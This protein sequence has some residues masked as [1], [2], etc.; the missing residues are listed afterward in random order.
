MRVVAWPDWLA[1]DAAEIARG[2]ER[3]KVRDKLERIADMLA[4]LDAR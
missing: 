3:G 1:L 4:V 2:R